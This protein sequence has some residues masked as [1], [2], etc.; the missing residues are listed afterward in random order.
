MGSYLPEYS[1]LLLLSTW[2]ISNKGEFS[3]RTVHYHYGRGRGSV[4]H[5]NTSLFVNRDKF[6][7]ICTEITV[8]NLSGG[9]TV[10]IWGGFPLITHLYRACDTRQHT[11]PCMPVEPVKNWSNATMKEDA[12]LVDFIFICFCGKFIKDSHIFS[13]RLLKLNKCIL[14]FYSSCSASTSPDDI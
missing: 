12:P 11:G 3:L 13:L 2:S 6:T 1:Y 14:K 9:R 7:I 5:A 8:N 4:L 10:N